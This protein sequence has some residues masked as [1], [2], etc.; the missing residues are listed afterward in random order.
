MVKCSG[1]G[2]LRAERNARSVVY[3]EESSFLPQGGRMMIA[4][5]MAASA[6][7]APQIRPKLSCRLRKSWRYWVT[8]FELKKPVE[9]DTVYGIEMGC[10]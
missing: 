9:I 7:I 3:G 6:V 8:S 4:V 2:V 5:I 10:A 1:S